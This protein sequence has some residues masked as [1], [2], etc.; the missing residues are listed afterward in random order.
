M[1][2][3]FNLTAQ[4]N[5]RGPSNI[6]PIIGQMRKELGSLNADVKFNIDK[7]VAK[8]IDTIRAKVDG[9]NASL[10]A[11]KANAKDLTTIFRD[12]Q[13]SLS[14]SKGLNIGGGKSLATTAA[15]AKAA[16]KNLKESS[17]AIEEFGQ[18][19]A[20]AFKRFA[21]YTVA[22]SGIFSLIN[23]VN[24]GVKS[25]IQFEKTLIA[26]RQV[27]GAGAVGIAAL[28]KE[29]TN[30]ATNLGVSSESLAQ[31]ATTLAQA[32]LS[33]NETRIALAALAKTELAPSFDNLTDTTEGAIAALRQFGLEATDL[34]AIL[35][36]I[37][38]VAAKFAVE[39]GDIIA[40]I[41]RTG[42]VFASASKG[43]SE[44]KDALNEFIAVFTSVRATTRESAET[45]ATG[46]RTIFTRIQ[47][48]KTIDQLK[49]FGVN[50]QDLE[51]K[52]VGPFE[53][54]KRL[55]EALNQL[56]PRDIRFATIVEELGGFRQIGKVIPL[57][58]Q[59]ATA[60][61]ALKV[62]QQGAGSLT[63]AQVLAQQ[64][65]ANQIAKVREQFLALIRDVGK[66]TT[67][68]VITKTVLTL[69]S[70]L[71]SLAGAF[72]PILPILGIL[73]TIKGISAIS[74]FASGFFGL[75]G[76]GGG[77]ATDTGDNV[78]QAERE[79]AEATN[80]AADVIREN[81]TAI[82]GLTGAIKSLESVIQARGSQTLNSGGKVLAFARGGFVPGSGNRDTVPAMLQPGEFVIRKKAVESVG[83]GNLERMNKYALGGKVELSGKTI[84]NT[85]S[86]LKD[87]VGLD[88]LYTANVDPIP[89]STKAIKPRMQKLKEQNPGYP[90]WKLFEYAVGERYGLS[91]AGGNKFLDFP[92]VLGEAKFMP[93]DGTY[94]QDKE[95][96]FIKGNN[97]ETMLA[98]LVGSGKYN[99][100]ATVRTYYPANVNDFR[101]FALGGL[102]QKFI[103]G[104]I[105][106]AVDKN[107]LVQ[108]VESLGGPQSVRGLLGSDKINAAIRQISTQGGTAPTAKQLF[109]KTFLNSKDSGPY[110][111]TASELL[112][113]A[114]LA[115]KKPRVFSEEEKAN[116][117]KLAVVGMTPFD[118]NEFKFEELAGRI[119]SLNLA[120]LKSDKAPAVEQMRSEIDRVLGGFAKNLGG[121]D[122]VDL[123]DPTK[124]AI[125]LGNLEGYMIEAVLAKLGANPGKLDDRSVDYANGL[126][127]AASLFGVDPNIPTEVKRDVKSGLSK[128]RENFANYFKKFADGGEAKK[129]KNF[130]KIGLRS[131]ASEV[132][133]TYFK[134]QDREGFV[135]AKKA[136]GDLFT[137]G[138]SKATKGYGPKLYDIVMEA[139]TAQGGMLASDRN[140]VSDAAK[141][142]WGFYF[143]NR[144][145]VKKTPLDPSQWTKNQN[146]ID[147]KLYGKKETWP[148]PNDPAW[149]L[150]SG[151]SKTP[152]LINSPDVVDMNDPKYAQFIKM[153]QASFLARNQ[154][155]SIRK[156]AKGGSS[157][158]TVPA[159]LTPGEFVINKKAAK[160]IGY[161][162]LKKLNHA[163]KMQGYNKGGL[164]GGVQS[165]QV[166]GPV[167]PNER[168]A[169]NITKVIQ[170]LEA[171]GTATP[172]AIDRLEEV[173]AK[174]LNE[175]IN[176][177]DGIYE[178]AQI[179][180]ELRA[181][182]DK[183][184]ADQIN[185]LGNIVN[186]I[187]STGD[188]Q[189]AAAEKQ[190]Q[191]IEKFLA[192]TKGKP[193]KAIVGQFP[194]Q[195]DLAAP[196]SRED[197]LAEVNADRK[198]AEENI[199]QAAF[200]AGKGLEEFI[201][202]LEDFYNTV[203]EQNLAKMQAQVGG[204]L[205]LSQTKQASVAAT[206]ATEKYGNVQ[207]GDFLANDFENLSSVIKEEIAARQESVKAAAE[208]TAAAKK[209]AED[210]KNS[211]DAFKDAGILGTA[212]PAQTI[213]TLKQ[214]NTK[215]GKLEDTKLLAFAKNFQTPK[216]LLGFSQALERLPGP[217][218][219]AVRAIGGLPGVLSLT[220]SVIGSDLLPKLG[221]LIG[222][223][224]SV[225]FAGVS[226]ALAE[227]GSRAVSMGTLGQQL[228]GPIVGLIA[229]IGGAISGAIAGAFK[230]IE[231]KQLQN[232]LKSLNS[233]SLDASRA[234]EKLSKTSSPENAN[235]AS[236]AVGQLQSNIRDLG[237]QA[238]VD[239][240]IDI[241]SKGAE[242]AAWGATIGGAIGTFL[243]PAIGTGVGA[244][245]GGGIG[246]VVGAVTGALSGADELDAEALKAQLEAVSQYIEGIDQLGQRRLKTR[247]IEEVEK[248]L[249]DLENARSP[250]QRAA[251]GARTVRVEEAQRSEL[252]LSGFKIE[253]NQNIT[254]F[255]DSLSGS[256]QQNAKDTAE[257]A[258][259]QYLYS[260]GMDELNKRYKG[261]DKAIRQ[262]SRNE[263]DVIALGQKRNLQLGEQEAKQQ[264]L[265]LAIK[266]VEQN[267]ANLSDTFKKINAGI[268]RFADESD[269]Y[270]K[271]VESS[272]SGL[273]G[274]GELR[275]VNR[276]N[277]RILS[278]PLAYSQEEVRRA[279]MNVEGL[280][281][282]GPEGA[283]IGNIALASKLIEEKLP[284]LLRG[285][286]K[287]NINPALDAI[288]G[289]FETAG[290]DVAT[291]PFQ[292]I[293][294]QISSSLESAASGGEGA[295]LGELG[296]GDD[297]I[298]K[299]SNILEKGRDVALNIQKEYNDTLQRSIDLQNKAN[300]LI[301]KANEFNRKAAEI[302]LNSE[303]ELSQRFGEELSLQQLNK[304]FETNI[305][306][307]TS[308]LIQGGSTDPQAIADAIIASNQQIS[309]REDALTQ[310]RNLVGLRGAAGQDQ[311]IVKAELDAIKREEEALNSQI[312]AT[313][314]ANQALESLANS[315]QA[316]ANALQ[317]FEQV[318]KK[319]TG[320]GN[321]IDKLLTSTPEEVN[322]FIREQQAANQVL[323]GT[324][325][326]QQLR[327]PEFRQMASQGIRGLEELLSPQEF[328]SAQAKF[329]RQ[330]LQAMG[331]DLNQTTGIKDENNN[332][333]TIDEL[334][335]RAEKPQESPE[336]QA[337]KDATARQAAAAEMMAKVNTAAADKYAQASTQII[338]F[339]KN[340]FGNIVKEAF[341]Q[342]RSVEAEARAA[343]TKPEPTPTQPSAAQKALAEAEQ[344]A[345]RS[346]AIAANATKVR[347]NAPSGPGVATA[348][349][350]ERDAIATAEADAA[351]VTRL[352]QQVQNEQKLAA[353]KAAEAQRQAKAAKDAQIE[354][355]RQADIGAPAPSSRMGVSPPAL[356]QNQAPIASDLNQAASSLNTSAQNLSNITA[357]MRASGGTA[358]TVG[359]IPGTRATMAAAATTVENAE[360]IQQQLSIRMD[361]TTQRFLLE[362]NG[363]LASTFTKFGTE[364][365][366]YV[367]RLEKIKLPETINLNAKH[368]VD[369]RITGAAAFDKLEPNLT[370]LV[371]SEVKK[372][373]AKLWNQSDGKYGERPA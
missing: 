57:I 172:E 52:F 251:V 366:R 232:S 190:T 191:A 51:G 350:Q 142:V 372:K 355:Q 6:R 323:T 43:V 31:V 222:L 154:G 147:P 7:N 28:E 87:R 211:G 257:A 164:V 20:L 254:D 126:G 177:K 312:R 230:G 225:G 113:E 284:A 362:F 361:E 140:A 207:L 296:I 186:A 217:V 283:Q 253:D 308:G 73:G 193:G 329:R 354:S 320:F 204:P 121:Q 13:S 102:V 215:T 305:R 178:T 247:T 262:A 291:G 275:S 38:A 367:D 66:S 299:I 241:L 134:N 168:A 61:E 160:K 67:F 270:V 365:G 192:S 364:F 123:D 276:E 221:E 285:T 170:T 220:A 50:L 344:S 327:R 45:I 158:D 206:A 112:K 101:N 202:D 24:Q 229:T 286:E 243:L 17:T 341:A 218:G 86:S 41:Q 295:T 74:Q 129:D 90:N 242:F 343:A 141:A 149:I 39:S 302:R 19:S 231:T 265:A 95:T 182:S 188:F 196:Q 213:K 234:L 12:L 279:G 274:N 330:S 137:I 161:G 42:G 288:R 122:L 197:L 336:L 157:E 180:K 280:A 150:Q 351:E 18:K 34:E 100:N 237:Q 219:N 175:T 349:S 238:Q 115:V 174:L 83:A 236:K 35:G 14:S 357:S 77:G 292:D 340:N 252:Q 195:E 166:G 30:L 371:V 173:V 208:A 78:A 119:V 297:L 56:D 4:L 184:S 233:N 209:Q 278:N 338:E 133:A 159:L 269:Q 15:S 210:Y 169:A 136:S 181:N 60:Q 272:V 248:F 335:T 356:A 263:A 58:Q 261:N 352:R 145:D 187:K 9:L 32:G 36:S 185:T 103:D 268:K 117:T 120:T 368:T 273:V 10:V 360:Q 92:S 167:T 26:L 309:Q 104:G 155:G 93:P 214:T 55:S 171:S 82:T 228:G 138:L 3:A 277:E 328:R 303:I 108:E 64:S 72:K 298:S 304:P 346:A 226:G 331:V 203:K 293:F 176:S 240:G 345:K 255:I 62:A 114:K 48:A 116:A 271:D 69:T 21:A 369:V 337:Y 264:K 311:S 205:T 25:F 324:A 245:I 1:A 201:T 44:G 144:N 88:D 319:V 244:A 289:Y 199:A 363:S 111:T 332:V 151:Y 153:Q 235:A 224:D 156:F 127:R 258:K 53:A 250:E 63:E 70:G 373:F 85:Y 287:G 79:R 23:A 358:G 189:S 5:L 216:A 227:G 301:L 65:L 37:N 347:E 27:T 307:L 194:P 267:F 59:F 249:T 163:D 282:G 47:R 46:L 71:I 98:K 326:A 223:G 256:A 68:Q 33:A 54:V 333:L 131:S 143:N 110:L 94:G 313:T 294:K 342:V 118:L 16:T 316:A 132:T 80:K 124:E 128:A 91:V 106:D 183:S 97:N 152:E 325:T 148:P 76:K 179:I 200:A 212:M 198:R 334:L 266:A 353:E 314:E 162:Q 29:I 281:G 2:N 310:R 246:A 339:F 84:S 105:A 109:S 89:Q 290:I 165:F 359:D 130:G 22:T 49:Q 318:Q 370:D 135:S 107:K 146:Y 315:T 96:G 300:Q 99:K 317:V 81:T 306:S 322:N 348:R 125:G 239:T 8:S 11:T 260:L 259:Q 75:G 40:A 139:V 321:I